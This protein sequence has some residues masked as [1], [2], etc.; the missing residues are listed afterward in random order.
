MAK[1]D[2][3]ELLSNIDRGNVAFLDKQPIEDHKHFSPY[4][5]SLWMAYGSQ[6][7]TVM[8]NE[9]VNPML[10][11][12]QKHKGLMYKM[13][14]ACSDGR[15]KRYQFPKLPKHTGSDP[16]VDVVRSFYDCSHL[17]ASQYASMLSL[18]IIKEMAR[19]VGLQDDEIKKLK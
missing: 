2:I 1:F 13:M 5:D 4:I 18:D 7:Q 6:Y 9:F 17:E 11:E 15:S 12:M 19:D 10:F 14:V 3:F 8:L 16:L